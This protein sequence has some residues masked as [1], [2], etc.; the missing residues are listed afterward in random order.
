[1][2]AMGLPQLVPLRE[3]IVSPGVVGAAVMLGVVLVL[4]VVLYGSRR[5]GKRFRQELEQRER[6]HEQAR[7]DAQHAAAVARCWEQWWRVVDTAGIEPAASEGAT[8]GLGPGGDLG[9]CAWAAARC[10]A[11]RR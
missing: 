1:M 9:A 2:T 11:A 10:R 5:A 4:C 6:H 7:E 8:L 3:F